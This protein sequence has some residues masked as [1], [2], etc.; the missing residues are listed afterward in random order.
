MGDAKLFSLGMGA[1]A[2]HS[3]PPGGRPRAAAR[4]RLS[5]GRRVSLGVSTRRAALLAA[6]AGVLVAALPPGGSRAVAKPARVRSDG[7]LLLATGFERGPV[8]PAT[9]PGLRTTTD[10]SVVLE[11]QDGVAYTGRA[12]YRLVGGPIAH[13]DADIVNTGS[14]RF[15][16]GGLEVWTGAAFNF[17][18]FPLVAPVWVMAT[19]PS[20]GAN[21][22]ADAKPVVKIAVDGRLVLDA[23]NVVAGLEP[24]FSTTVLVPGAWYYLTIHGRNGADQVQE[25]YIYDGATHRLLEVVRST[26]TVTGD[27]RDRLAKWGFGTA[28][29]STG[30]EY[31]LDDLSHFIGPVNPGPVRVLPKSATATASNGG[32]TTV[33]AAMPHLGI[34]EAPADGDATHIRNDTASKAAHEVTFT[35]GDAALAPADTVHAVQA[36]VVARTARTA[37]KSS[38]TVVAGIANGSAAAPLASATV[39]ASYAA[40]LV[41]YPRSPFTSAPWSPSEVDAIRGVIRDAD[42]TASEFR[43]TQA[44][45]EV[46]Y[47]PALPAPV[48]RPA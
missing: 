4:R 28:Q 47:S 33:G 38:A 45:W 14:K 9:E 21:H 11:W 26:W 1:V 44:T 13:G 23:T 27:H 42:R 16:L 39:P 46:V 20:D 24:A 2:R 30:L 7:P 19:M 10:P 40:R 6:L 35:L 43:V 31:Y 37:W 34:G 5:G 29:D 8:S 25:L 15:P 22:G 36:M 32:F 3:A 18:S 48:G 41:R 17:V 12:A